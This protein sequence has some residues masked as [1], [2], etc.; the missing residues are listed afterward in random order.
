M[1]WNNQKIP[2]GQNAVIRQRRRNGELLK[3]LA[4]DYGVTTQR[5][6]YITRDLSKKRRR[7]D[8]K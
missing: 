8:A 3:V 5:I 7:S 6:G 1:K 4:S 2:T